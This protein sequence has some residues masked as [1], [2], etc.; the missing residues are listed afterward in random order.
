MDRSMH[1]VLF[2]IMATVL[3]GCTLAYQPPLDV[4][5]APYVFSGKGGPLE[6]IRVE[7]VTD[8]G[9]VVSSRGGK[10]TL[11]AKLSDYGEAI[12]TSLDRELVKNGFQVTP[13]ASKTIRIDVIDVEMAYPKEYRCDINVAIGAGDKTIGIAT[14]SPAS[15]MYTHAIDDAIADAVRRIMGNEEVAAFLTDRP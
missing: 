8:P 7:N 1:A 9:T 13:E 3:S 14:D 12:V 15:L 10:L 11:E 4:P 6:P 5:S 2:L